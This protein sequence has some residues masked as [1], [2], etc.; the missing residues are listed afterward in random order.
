MPISRISVDALQPGIG[1]LA[2]SIIGAKDAYDHGYRQQALAESSLGKAAASARLDNAKADEVQQQLAAQQPDALLDNALTGL[3][4]PLA[5]REQ[6]K[7]FIQTGKIGAFGPQAD[8]TTVPSP[9][10]TKNLG[11]LGRQ[12]MSTRNA[13]TVGDKN[14]LNVAK[15]SGEYRDQAL[16]DQILQGSLSPLAASVAQYAVSGKA[17]YEFKEYGVGNNLTGQVDA[18]GAPAQNF[19]ELRKAEAG[20]NVAQ[21]GA[22]NASAANSYASAGQHRAATNKINQDIE[23]GGKGQYD[24]SRGIIVN[25]R[26]GQ[27][28]QVVGPDGQPIAAK[29]K[30]LNE[31]QAKAN[32]FGSRAQAADQVLG[33]LAAQGIYRPSMIKQGAESLPL[34]GGAAGAAANA[35][36][37]SPK[38][39]QVEQ[40]QRDFINAVLRRE[41]GAAIAESEFD[42]ARK[43]YFPQPGDSRQVIEQKARNRQLAVQGILQEVPAGKRG[44]QVP[45][46]AG[47]GKTI[48]VDY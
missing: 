28:I 19:A 13:L 2:R 35:L 36:F 30:D 4:V 27:A 8:G 37:A 48:S 17:P 18:T 34:V 38:Q 45:S 42:N 41:S 10:W 14:S 46:A 24:S 1:G 39:Q 43:Q 31:G 40:A 25:P 33:E 3:G 16:G 23:M 9:D 15:A 29:D 5:A 7:E 47:G 11:A 32:L 22:A 6:A 21:A 12:L 26:T 20:K 44:V